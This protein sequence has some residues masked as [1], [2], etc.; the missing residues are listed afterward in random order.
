MKRES[1][2]FMLDEVQRKECSCVEHIETI[3]V[4]KMVL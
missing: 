3:H 1:S 4:G 2:I